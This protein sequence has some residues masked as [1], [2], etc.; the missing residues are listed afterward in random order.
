MAYLIRI[1]KNQS[2]NVYLLDRTRTLFGR[3]EHCHVVFQDKNV[4]REHA[5]FEHLDGQIAI[6]DHQSSNGTFVND[7]PVSKMILSSGDRIRIG[8][9]EMIYHTGSPEELL[10]KGALPRLDHERPVSALRPPEGPTELFALGGDAKAMPTGAIKATYLQLKTLYRLNQELPN[11]QNATGLYTTVAE[12][13]LLAMDAERVIIWES[14]GVR[15]AHEAAHIAYAPE[16]EERLRNAPIAENAL[17]A[18]WKDRRALFFQTEQ[19]PVTAT[20]S[21]L[22][23]ADKH[24]MLGVPIEHAGKH[25]G[26]ILI[27]NPSERANLAKIDLDFAASVARLIGLFIERVSYMKSLERNISVM[28][29]R[30]G[31]SSD[32][33]GQSAE[34]R[35]I[36]AQ[37]AQV[38]VTDAT[39]LIHGESGT[40][41]EIVARSIHQSSA[42]GNNEFLAVNCAGLP[43]NLVES[44]LFGYEKGAFT[45][46]YARKL[47]HFESASMGTLFL[48]EVGEL[49]LSAQAKLLRVLQEGEIM[50]VGGNK[51]IRVD[52]RI[53]TATNR[54]LMEMVKREKF[55]EDLY[56]RLNVVELQLP[57]L[58]ERREDIP[59]LAQYFFQQLRD[60][61]TAGRGISDDALAALS[62]YDW[63]GNIR[64]LRNAIEHALVMAQGQTIEREH[65]PTYLTQ[66]EKSKPR[67]IR[68]EDIA[69]H[70][71]PESLSD[72]EKRHIAACLRHFSGNKQKTAQALG[73]SRSTLYEKMKAYDLDG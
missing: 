63:P 47:G 29:K 8:E 35:K 52:V 23:S 49:S 46:A 1:E 3:A 18:V 54:N 53:I 58:R 11:A 7:I 9:S 66:R 39:V 5:T 62:D 70:F 71:E 15:L 37:I 16:L 24:S 4:S 21:P 57:P 44:E 61:L 30:A 38:A 36:H 42:R 67:L 41:K 33:I 28:A 40:G 13:M 26:V 22:S 32:I 27:D 68:Q 55:R 51:P 25:Y 12:P 59:V 72:I 45:G 6:I 65:L 19:K 31:G 2:T 10:E 56:Y 17:R 64:Q 14:A 20:Q 60:S 73:I 50:R 34:I 48:D 69:T 43:E